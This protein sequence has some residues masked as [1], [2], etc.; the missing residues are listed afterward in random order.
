M[1]KYFAVLAL[2]VVCVNG[3]CPRIPSI[4]HSRYDKIPGDNGY[5]IKVNENPSKYVPGK[6]Y[7]LYLMGTK[8]LPEVQQ[9]QRFII[10]VQSSKDP[11]N[12][13]PQSVGSFQLYGD[14]STTFNEECVNT[15]SERNAQLK[16]EV[17]FMWA[18]PPPGSG[19][20][21]FRAMVLED[22]EH[23][24]A[25]D[26]G[27]SK[28][29]CEQ[30]DKDIKFDEND[31]CSCD[32]AK[33]SVI[34][35]GLWSTGTHPKDFP[36]SLWLT[37]FSDVIGAS[38][39]RNFSFWGEG[40]IASEGFR[41]LAEWGSVRLMETE[42][43]ASTRYIRTIIK[44]A[45]LWYP[46]V[47]TNTSTNFKVDRKHHLVSLASMFGPS[48]DWVV[49]V[50]GLNLCL[51]N[52]TW[53]E[54]L[55]VDLFPYDAGTDSGITYMSPNAETSP[56]EKMYRITTKYPEDPRAPFYDPRKDEMNPLARLYFKREKV[57]PR[58]C[59]ESF[60]T[61]QVD[62]SENTEEV[63]R[64]ECAVTEY[65]SWSACSVTC[66]KGLRMRT[67]EYV[68]PQK[69]QM[70]ECNRQLISKEM[71]V[72]DVPE[73]EGQNNEDESREDVVPLE[74]FDGA[75]EGIC[76]TG[77]WGSWS[78]CSET[79]GVG[80]KMRSRFFLDNMGRKKCPHITTVE[81]EKCMGPQCTSVEVKDPMCPT[82]DW[83][84]WSPCSASCGKGVKFRTKLLMV[85]PE[86]QTKCQGRVELIQ[87]QPCMDTPDC[88]FDMA[89]AKVVCMQ[90][91]DQ[92][93]CQGY[94]NR[95]YFDS[96]KLMCVPFVYG[97]CRGNKNNFLT[98]G[99]CMESCS[100]VRD[101]LIGN[102]PAPVTPPRTVS[103]QTDGFRVAPNFIQS[104]FD[105]FGEAIDCMVTPW[106]PW[107][108]CSATCGIG[109]EERFRMIKRPAQNGGKAC[110]TNL[111]KKR[112]CYGPIPCYPKYLQ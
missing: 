5:Q 58:Q 19:C 18:A 41:S 57:I 73:C 32:E 27:L 91:S 105:G 49:G 34:F 97:G 46:Q 68:I 8:R 82:T 3:Q 59:D 36:S 88:T 76:S 7:T 22:A 103:R 37:H 77:P 20:V 12:I 16:T 1:W 84:D 26:G 4:Y 94:Y 51:K 92:G 9:F 64:P 10:N 79:C 109:V 75:A 101:A 15:I 98:S 69:A 61:A 95:W 29:F 52:C 63:S 54:N 110:P 28:T 111:K 107:S 53:I 81:K 55:V 39:E 23:W 89:T 93:P 99:D 50:N 85:S 33:Y 17:F 47:N 67:R 11:E 112:R 30:T 21:T 13:S 102:A 87:Q 31:C 40:Q 106:S 65:T 104:G 45:G 100:V 71:C 80:F 43:R 6:L 2:V 42:L 83:S 35:E 38:H 66:G 24:Y 78:T 108:Q 56:R 96:E 44:A 90:T 86:L 48:P 72:A 70:F 62:V 74:N 14:N 25:D 60:L